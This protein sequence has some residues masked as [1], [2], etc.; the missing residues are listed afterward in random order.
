MVLPPNAS[1]NMRASD[2]PATPPRRSPS[3][4]RPT[5]PGARGNAGSRAAVR[6]TPATTAAPPPSWASLRPVAGR[7]EN[8]PRP[9]CSLPPNNKLSNVENKLLNVERKQSNDKKRCPCTKHTPRPLPR[10]PRSANDCPMSEHKRAKRLCRLK[11]RPQRR[12]TRDVGTTA[13]SWPTSP[14]T[15]G[16]EAAT[17]S[18]KCCRNLARI[19]R[20]HSS[21][22][23]VREFAN[24]AQLLEHMPELANVSR[25]WSIWVSSVGCLGVAP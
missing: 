5:T 21:S 13:R 16:P 25:S 22:A 14:E 24:L 23:V 11:Y 1:P 4:A 10:L 12:T 3:A 7:T 20:R 6:K 18:P 9:V 19:G 8:A 15:G 17:H 2:A